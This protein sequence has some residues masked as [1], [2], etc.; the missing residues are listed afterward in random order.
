MVVMAVCGVLLGLGLLAGWRWGGLE[1]RPPPGGHAPSD[2]ARRYVWYLAVV[3]VAGLGAGLLVAGAGGRLM[4]RLL[5]ATSPEEAQGRLTEADEVVGQITVDGT[6]GFVAFTGLF[7]GLAT[8]AAYLLVRPWLPSGRLG[9]FAFGG[10]LL[11]A[12]GTRVEPLRGDNPD[13]DVVGPAWLSLLGFGVLVVAHGA[14][15]AAVAARYASTLPL[16]AWQP[17]AIAGHAPLLLLLPLV[18]P[19]LV[20]V[21]GGLVVVGL[22]QVKAIRAGLQAPQAVAVGRVVLGAAALVALPGFISV[23]IDIAKRGS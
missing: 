13:F 16:L 18:L 5:A 14:V 8:G 3:V 9:G 17:R 6:I 23:V 2:V 22:S 1:I 21:V 15:V 4:M 10:L 7:F 20:V 19:A 11:V 12:A